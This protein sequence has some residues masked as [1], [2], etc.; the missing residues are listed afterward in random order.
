MNNFL[1]KMTQ[2]Q[3][4]HSDRR[5]GGN[6]NR[7]IRN[8]I[9]HDSNQKQIRLEPLDMDTKKTKGTLKANLIKS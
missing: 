9:K 5:R 4:N 3:V 6:H 8:D 2:K 7:N 1:T